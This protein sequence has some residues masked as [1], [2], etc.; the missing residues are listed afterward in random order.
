MNKAADMDEPSQLGKL[1]ADTYS[2]LTSVNQQGSWMCLYHQG[3]SQ[4]VNREGGMKW[5]YEKPML[6]ILC[7]EIKGD[8]QKENLFCNSAKQQIKPF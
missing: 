1:I 3:G 4:E 6:L 5:S 2:L 8:I 7:H